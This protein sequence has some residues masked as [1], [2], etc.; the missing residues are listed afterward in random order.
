MRIPLSDA[1]VRSETG[2]AVEK[3]DV[4]ARKHHDPRRIISAR[5]AVEALQQV[6]HEAGHCDGEA[7][8]DDDLVGPQPSDH[9]RHHQSDDGADCSCRDCRQRRARGRRGDLDCDERAG[10]HHRLEAQVDEAAD[11][12]DEAA[13][14]REEDR[15]CRQNRGV[16]EEIDHEATLWPAQPKPNCATAK[17]MTAP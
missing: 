5:N 3:G 1:P 8:A 6:P 14:S 2:N 12:V 7:Q 17:I 11:P 16:K 4:Q 9:E 10:Q 13:D 15:G